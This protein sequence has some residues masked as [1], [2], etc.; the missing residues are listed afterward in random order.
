MEK[1]PTVITVFK[2]SKFLWGIPPNVVDVTFV[3][4]PLVDCKESFCVTNDLMQCDPLVGTQKELIMMTPGLDNVKVEENQLIQLVSDAPKAKQVIPIY[5]YFHICQIGTWRQVVRDLFNNLVISGLL[6]QAD[7]LC[8]GILGDSPEQ[9]LELLGYHPKARI[10]ASNPDCSIFERLTLH[11]LRRRAAKETFRA[12]YLHSKGVM[13]LQVAPERELAVKAWVSYL[14]YWNIERW[15]DCLRA[16][17][18]ASAVGCEW[19]ANHYRGNFWWANS[20]YLATLPETIGPSYTDPEFWIALG[21]QNAI[22]FNLQNSNLYPYEDVIPEE[23][24]RK[25]AISY[26]TRIEGTLHWLSNRATSSAW[27]DIK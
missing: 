18:I 25:R 13:R 17:D 3:L 10:V 20:S 24:Y 19:L 26:P 15:R 7:E 14:V 2:D 6:E 1:E 16:L 4:K 5:I 11:E 8:L 22:M 27:L 21:T 12:F 23:L 9:V